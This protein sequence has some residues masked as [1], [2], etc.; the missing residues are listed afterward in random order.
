M[1]ARCLQSMP[2]VA[3]PAARHHQAGAVEL[4]SDQQKV[5]QRLEGCTES[6]QESLSVKGTALVWEETQQELDPAFVSVLVDLALMY[7]KFY[8]L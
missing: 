5:S 8:Y 4:D 2:G 7:M 3:L 6:R 1:L